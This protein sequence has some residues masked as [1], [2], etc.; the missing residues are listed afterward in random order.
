MPL[1]QM[2]YCWMQVPHQPAVGTRRSAIGQSLALIAVRCTTGLSFMNDHDQ[3]EAQFPRSVTEP[4]LMLFV[5]E[6]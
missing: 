4:M 1:G 6:R 5:G 3:L 2:D